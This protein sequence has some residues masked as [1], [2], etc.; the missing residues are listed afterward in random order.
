M[1]HISVASGCRY[2]YPS[3]DFSAASLSTAGKSFITNPKRTI[4]GVFTP[5]EKGGAP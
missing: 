3:I 4:A 5:Q 1:K 2:T